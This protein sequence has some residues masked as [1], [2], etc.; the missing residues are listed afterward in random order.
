MDCDSIS[1]N[2]HKSKFKIQKV[3]SIYGNNLK[4][5]ISCANL[6]MVRLILTTWIKLSQME[7]SQLSLGQM[8]VRNLLHTELIA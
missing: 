6:K 8:K 2:L 3:A 1:D 5:D 4:N 7:R